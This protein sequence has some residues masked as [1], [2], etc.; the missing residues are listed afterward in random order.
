VTEKTRKILANTIPYAT[1]GGAIGW[2]S[3][4]VDWISWHPLLVGTGAAVG[5]RLLRLANMQ[6]GRNFR[7]NIEH[8]SAR[9][10]AEKDIR[11][12]I[13]KKAENNI[14]LTASESITMNSRPRRVKYARSKNVLVV[15][16]SGSGKTRFFVKPNLMQCQ[17][18][19]F[20]T[21]FVVTDPKGTLLSETG[22]LL[23]RNGYRIKVLNTIDFSK[24]MRY[25]PFEYI[26]SEKD[27]LK[28]V[29]AL[30]ANTQGDDGKSSQDP[31]WI[32][33]EMLLY[34]AL[35]A[36]IH[37]EAHPDEK[38]MNSLVDMIN[39]MEIREDNENFKN[40]VDFTF[41]ALEERDPNHF[42]LRQYKK[43]K[44]AAGKTAKSILVQCGARLSPFDIGEVRDFVKYDELDLASIGEKKTAFF[45]IVSDTDTSF[46]FLPAIMYSQ[47]FNLLCDKADN[48]YGGRLPIHVRF[49]L[50]EFPN[51][52]KIPNF[53]KL[54]ATIRS[55]EISA[56]VILQTQSQLKALYK[57]SAETI[58]GNCDSILFLGGNEKTT[59]TEISNLL[60]KE[61]ITVCNT[62]Q[63]RGSSGSYSQTYQKTGRDLMT[64]DE[65]AKLD[66]DMCILQ[67]RGVPP[68][69]SKKYDL[70]Q[71]PN[72]RYIADYDKRNKFNVER[73]LSTKLRIKSSDVFEVFEWTGE[74]YDD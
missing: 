50:D 53:D 6:N 5:L 33:A 35:I 19:D 12:Y 72:Y 63:S 41:E 60:G 43:Y 13:D 59:L 58:I 9:W 39:S 47:L 2:Y 11:R 57:E 68:F 70:T 46:N 28:F 54:I 17:S 3:A 7:H 66:G 52:G 32:K 38:N 42:A 55:R 10:G 65:L 15:G 64:T 44:L 56:C 61:T 49:L 48:E 29:T 51:L 71:H 62:S 8:G 27:I 34:Q 31:F 30:I 25:N 36:Y 22:K 18:A 45:V 26:R 37:Y 4:G 20:P 23:Q 16:G 21:S 67:V 14:I 73:Y 69:K 24:S 1:V 74:V 40:A